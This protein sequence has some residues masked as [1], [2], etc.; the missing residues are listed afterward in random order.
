MHWCEAGIVV[1]KEYAQ[2]IRS[3]W[4][5]AGS[6]TGCGQEREREKDNDAYVNQF[7]YAE[8]IWGV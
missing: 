5:F 8:E 1:R 3:I 4:M 7:A 6:C 2:S